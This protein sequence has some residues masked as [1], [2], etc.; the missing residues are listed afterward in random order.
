MAI[1]LTINRGKNMG[2]SFIDDSCIRSPEE[3]R[4][5][6][7]NCRE[8]IIKDEIQRRHKEQAEKILKEQESPK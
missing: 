3:V 7:D 6:L 8:I 2:M 1:A 5:I 4:Q